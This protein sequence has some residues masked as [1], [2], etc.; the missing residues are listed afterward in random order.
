MPP[1]SATTPRLL[2]SFRSLDQTIKDGLA[3]LRSP[4]LLGFA[5]LALAS[6]FAARDKLSAE[7][8]VAALEAAGVAVERQAI[9]RAF[10]RAANRISRQNVEDELFFTLM[11]R[12]K[13]EIEPLLRKGTIAVSFIQAGQPRSA[14]RTLAEL[15]STLNGHVRICDPYYGAKSL[16]SLELIPTA[17]TVH[18]LTSQWSDRAATLATTV[19]DFYRARPNTNIRTVAA[20][21]VLHDRYVVSDSGLLLLGHG[22]KD[23]GTRDSCTVSI[24]VE[25]AEDLLTELRTSFDTKWA[26][27]TPV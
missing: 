23:I 5:A 15:F 20:P 18:L 9:T 6:Q 11:I 14:R 8:I 22:I 17:C 3:D 10:S 4:L 12:G 19:P 1:T 21:H 16:D 7:E 25:Y 2:D 24:G 13:R 26:T 27:A